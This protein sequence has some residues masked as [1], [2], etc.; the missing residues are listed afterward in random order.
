LTK[1][2]NEK[3]LIIKA[4]NLCKGNKSEAAKM[5]DINRKTLYNKLKLYELD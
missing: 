2:E 5:L 1:S 3:D 4:L